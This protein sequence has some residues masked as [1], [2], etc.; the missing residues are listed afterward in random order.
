MMAVLTS[1]FDTALR[2]IQPSEADRNNA[3][4][5]HEDVRGV[6]TGAESLKEWGLS[7][8]LIGSYRRRV[9]IQRVYDVDVFCRMDDISA[10]V[11][12]SEVLDRGM[13]PVSRSGLF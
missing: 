5:A 3:P 4:K 11:E 12:P 1:N 2:R 10:D 8:I 13:P 6:L 9:A 7:P